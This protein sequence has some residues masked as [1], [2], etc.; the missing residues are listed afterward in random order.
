MNAL[1]ST[2]KG[3]SSSWSPS[4]SLVICRLYTCAPYVHYTLCRAIQ[5]Y[6]LLSSFQVL[7]REG[8]V[9][10]CYAE[11]G[12]LS[13]LLA[14]WWHRSAFVSGFFLCKGSWAFA[15]AGCANSFVLLDVSLHLA[16]CVVQSI[17]D[18]QQHLCWFL[19]G[20]LAGYF[21]CLKMLLERWCSDGLCYECK[22]EASFTLGG[23]YCNQLSLLQY[24][25]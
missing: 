24:Y 17:N 12:N 10:S 23:S 22:W 3:L 16:I 1:I 18:I 6:I 25:T 13:I 11:P 2:R 7:V 8:L 4:L 21:D 15:K 5:Q 9:P 19:H 14:C 20:H